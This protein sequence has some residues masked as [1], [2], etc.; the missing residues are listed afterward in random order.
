MS[1]QNTLELSFYHV[2]SG[3]VRE[4]F[5]IIQLSDLHLKE[6]G[7][8]NQELVERV[9]ILEPDIIA[10]TGDM[11]MEQNDDYHVVL[12]LCRQLVEITDVYYVMGNHELVDY[13]HRRTRIRE[14]IEKTG[15][16]M[17]FNHAETHPGQY[18]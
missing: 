8:N 5:R 9:K 17:L 15:V 10:I 18:Q 12:D 6:F 1:D 4:G 3:K 16:H 13:A 2:K 11:N 14:D 7:E